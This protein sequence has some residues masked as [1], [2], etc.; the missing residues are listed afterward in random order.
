MG[1]ILA[2]PILFTFSCNMRCNCIRVF[3]LWNGENKKST[4]PQQT[5]SGEEASMLMI[6]GIIVQS[7]QAESCLYLE[8]VS[9][10]R[11]V[12]MLWLLSMCPT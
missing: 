1:H 6:V 4:M 8:M 7:H 9:G 2:F 10:L 3:K 12:D 5:L 11:Y